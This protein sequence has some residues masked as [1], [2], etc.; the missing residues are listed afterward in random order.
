M[1]AMSKFPL[2]SPQEVRDQPNSSRQSFGSGAI[3]RVVAAEGA[4]RRP[5]VADLPIPVRQAAV[6]ER[7]PG[8][9][10]FGI[11]AAGPVARQWRCDS[12]AEPISA[13]AEWAIDVTRKGVIR[14]S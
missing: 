9:G 6:T 5:V 1:V 10:G 11:I 7:S 8:N 12:G 4:P 14:P 2:D 13:I 3:F